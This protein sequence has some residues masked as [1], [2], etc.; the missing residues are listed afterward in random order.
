MFEMPTIH[1]VNLE[2]E[3]VLTTSPGGSIGGDSQFGS[4]EEE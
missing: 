3:D 4:G 1:I 2:V